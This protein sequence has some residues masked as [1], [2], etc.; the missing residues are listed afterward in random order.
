LQP[1]RLLTQERHNSPEEYFSEAVTSSGEFPHQSH[2]VVTSVRTSTS[3]RT[4]LRT[5]RGHLIKVIQD[6]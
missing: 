1:R 5:K 3:Q 6:I 4:A 2:Q